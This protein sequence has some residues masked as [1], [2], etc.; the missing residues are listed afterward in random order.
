MERQLLALR[1]FGLT[2]RQIV[3]DRQSGKDFARPGYCRLLRRLKQGDTLVIKSIDRLGRNYGE[4]LEQ[5]RS[6]TREKGAEI[7]VL[8]MP[9]LDTRKSRD[10]AGTL[11]ADMKTPAGSKSRR[12]RSPPCAGPF[13]ARRR[14]LA[15]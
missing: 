11:I 1:E 13:P 10:L 15:R 5:W 8:D 6:I 4:I 12:R 3:V 9:L 14:N 7:V 2:E